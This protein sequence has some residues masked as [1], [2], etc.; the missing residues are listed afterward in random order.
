MYRY[1]C[2][3]NI[4]AHKIEISNEIE[5]HYLLEANLQLGTMI[6]PRHGKHVPPH[7]GQALFF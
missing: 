4:Q 2:R 1:T 6:L 5:S 7:Q 3:Q